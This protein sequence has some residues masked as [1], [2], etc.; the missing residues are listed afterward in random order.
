[1]TADGKK[2]A[3]TTWEELQEQY[4]SDPDI[5]IEETGQDEF[6]APKK[7]KRRKPGSPS[8]TSYINSQLVPENR[9]KLTSIED[10]KLDPDMM[11]EYAQNQPLIKQPGGYEKTIQSIQKIHGWWDGPEGYTP[12]RG[13]AGGDQVHQQFGGKSNFVE[14]SSQNQPAITEPY[15]KKEAPSVPD[16]AGVIPS[17]M[18]EQAQ[19]ATGER[20]VQ[21]SGGMAAM[22][23]SSTAKKIK[24]AMDELDKLGDRRDRAAANKRKRLK[25]EIAAL[26]K[27]MD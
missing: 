2:G 1:M 8:L 17:G 13:G 25:E 27:L 11:W 24:A 22:V 12:S 14:M 6:G 18:L 10:I 23:A 20:K 5:F 16:A 19:Q 21:Q 4:M 7:I 15:E 9:F 3:A 26:Q